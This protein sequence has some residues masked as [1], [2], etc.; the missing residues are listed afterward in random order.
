MLWLISLTG[1]S[2]I[3]V[4]YRSFGTIFNPFFVTAFPVY[5]ALYGG[6]FIRNLAYPV[7][8]NLYTDIII[9]TYLISLLFGSILGYFFLKK[10]NTNHEYCKTSNLSVSPKT[11]PYLLVIALL[12]IVMLFNEFIQY[13]FT[14]NGFRHFYHESRDAGLG[15]YFYLLGITLPLLVLISFSKGR[16]FYAL[17]FFISMIFM[18]KKQVFMT[19]ALMILAYVV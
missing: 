5:F 7:E 10:I 3:Y 6:N 4:S 9:L 12:C 13:P 8:Q 2:L 15:V 19:S 11:Y 1:L 14:F 17:L 16:I 18:G